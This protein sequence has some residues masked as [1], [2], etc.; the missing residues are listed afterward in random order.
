M[1]TKMQNIRMRHVNQFAI[2]V[3]IVFDYRRGI[4]VHYFLNFNS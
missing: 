2:V 4:I 1:Y 3:M